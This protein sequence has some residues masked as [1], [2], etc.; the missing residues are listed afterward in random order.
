M[1]APV[2][3][4]WLRVEPLLDQALDLPPDRR[5]EFLRS[6]CGGDAALREVIER[7]LHAA[8]R[9]DDLLTGPAAGFAA[10]MVAWVDRRRAET[11][12]PAGFAAGERLGPYLIEGELGRGG[13]AAVYR[14]QDSRD[15]GTVALKVLRAEI[16]ALLGRERFAREIAI[17]A[18]L[19]HPRILPL[20]ESGSIRREDGT[21]VVYYTMPCMSGRS[22]RDRLREQP[23]LPLDEAVRVAREVSSALAHAHAAGVVHRDIKPENILLDEDGVRVADFGIARALDEAGGERITTSGL[24][25]GTPAYMSPEQ[26]WGGPL[27]GRADVYALGCVLYEMLAGTPPFTGA[28]AQAIFARHAAGQVPPLATVRPDVGD[29]LE[30]IVLRTLAKA[31]A[32]RFPSAAALES[33]LADLG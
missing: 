8:E 5:A 33:A 24:I 25:L 32:N 18:R 21:S 26:G 6:A 30:R 17:A 29:G 20:Y 23:Q 3:D 12:A 4:R 15:G 19:S 13:M 31:P 9:A 27:D 7:L 1:G 2:G 16:A 28:T 14:A 11:A 22:V 10:P